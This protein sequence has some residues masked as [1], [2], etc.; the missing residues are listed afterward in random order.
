MRKADRVL[1]ELVAQTNIAQIVGWLFV[2]KFKNLTK[3]VESQRF[4]MNLE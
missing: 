2:L 4:E 1:G 3:G